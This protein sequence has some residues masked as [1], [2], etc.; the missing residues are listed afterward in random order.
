M[1]FE[2][3]RQAD[4]DSVYAIN[5][6]YIYPGEHL[7]QTNIDLVEWLMDIFFSL[8]FPCLVFSCCFV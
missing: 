8:A 1:L 4:S 7:R 5:F 2:R 6:N 3:S